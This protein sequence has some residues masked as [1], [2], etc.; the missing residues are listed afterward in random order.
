ML[1]RFV[2]F[3]L[4]F[5]PGI[6][7]VTVLLISPLQTTIGL[8]ANKL[9]LTD[10]SINEVGAGKVILRVNVIGKESG[11]VFLTP[12][13]RLAFTKLRQVFI[14]ASILYYIHS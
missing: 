5:M 9:I 11:T 10:D 4:E 1:L 2:N 13:A 8:I 3:Y 6:S 12:R 14:I 7:R